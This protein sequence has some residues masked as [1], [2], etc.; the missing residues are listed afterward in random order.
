[1]LRT[2]RFHILPLIALALLGSLSA[3]RGS[4]GAENIS[5]S[6]IGSEQQRSSETQKNTTYRSSDKQSEALRSDLNLFSLLI[7]KVDS[8]TAISLLLNVSSIIKLND[9]ER[10][11]T[12]RPA[13]IL[14]EN[15]IDRVRQAA[16]TKSSALPVKNA[17][18]IK[19]SRFSLRDSQDLF[20]PRKP[21]SFDLVYLSIEDRKT[22]RKKE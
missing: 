14:F 21:G 3:V 5:D 8:D 18:F 2:L 20:Q 19:S 15:K 13:D 1:M 17:Q 4:Y 22:L 11:N 6:E 12:G 9:T 10:R 7:D 16:A